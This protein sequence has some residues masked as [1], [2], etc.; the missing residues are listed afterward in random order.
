MHWRQAFWIIGAAVLAGAI[1]L[2]AS[3]A[4]YG[5]GPAL[6]NSRLGEWLGDSTPPGL[7]VIE[8]GEVMPALILRDLSGRPHTI[9]R[10]GRLT[11]INYWASWCAP[12][13]QEMPLLAAFAQSDQGGGIDLIGIA[14]DDPASAS[15]FLRVIPVPFTTLVEMPGERDSSVQLGDRR[16]LLPFSVL[17]GAD[18]RLLKRRVGPFQSS[19]QVAAWVQ[20][21]K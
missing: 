1:G 7:H 5:P 19:E 9:P 13:R 20:L 3:V 10:P 14:L 4:L 17:I 21:A 11:L 2:V 18:G 8:P 6:M 16:G 12:C 15:E